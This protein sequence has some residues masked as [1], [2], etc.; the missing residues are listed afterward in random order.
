MRKADSIL[1]MMRMRQHQQQLRDLADAYFFNK[2]I[3]DALR[4][5]MVEI[6]EVYKHLPQPTNNIHQL[7][8]VIEAGTEKRAKQ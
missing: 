6:K 3:T 1:Q 4:T 5:A 7:R 8:Q 2:R